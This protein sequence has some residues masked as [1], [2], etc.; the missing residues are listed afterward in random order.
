M[1]Y[2]VN[3]TRSGGVNE[4]RLRRTVRA[5]MGAVGAADAS[6]S[7]TIVGDRAM[8]TLNRTHRD[9][10]TPTDVLSFPLYPPEA[11][12]RRGP[13]RPRGREAHERLLGDIVISLDTAR[14]QAAAYDAPVAR[15]LERLL[16]HGML[17][18]CGHDHLEP[19]ERRVM[20]REE[21]RLADLIGMPW[22]YLRD[23]APTS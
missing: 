7:L 18:L 9:K 6:I 21:R 4:A 5:L 1:M 19:A 12:V 10:D 2:F 3:R 14:R 17:H 8:R 23:E 22:P 16:I 15:E 11:F 13:T 20:V